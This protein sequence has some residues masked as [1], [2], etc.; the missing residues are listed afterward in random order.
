M[1]VG[2]P[3]REVGLGS[4]C[5]PI[6][7]PW[8]KAQIYTRSQRG[9]LA[10][11]GTMGKSKRPRAHRRQTIA[12]PQAMMMPTPFQ[13]PMMMP[14]Q[15]PMMMPQ[16]CFGLPPQK[17]DPRAAA[18]ISSS[19]SSRSSISAPRAKK[20]HTRKSKIPS[21]VQ[22]LGGIGRV[23]KGEALESLDHR[24]DATCLA[25]LDDAYLDK[26]LWILTSV[27]PTTKLADLRVPTWRILYGKLAISNKRVVERLSPVN[28]DEMVKR[29]LP[30]Q[31]EVIDAVAREEGWSDSYASRKR[32]AS[33]VPL[34]LAGMSGQP[35]NGTP[36]ASLMDSAMDVWARYAGGLG[37]HLQPMD[38]GL[39]AM[40]DQM[41]TTWQQLLEPQ[42]QASQPEQAPT[43]LEDR[44][45]LQ[46][47]QQHAPATPSAPVQAPATP[48]APQQQH[49]AP[50]APQQQPAP[51]T[52]SAPQPRAPATPQQPERPPTAAQD[53]E[54]PEGP[55]VTHICVICQSDMSSGQDD[56]LEALRCGHVFHAICLQEC[57][58]VTG[59]S[60]EDACPFKCKVTAA[61]IARVTGGTLESEEAVDDE[62]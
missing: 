41:G 24:L 12:A 15:Q 33:S 58:T 6:G 10:P 51:A 27:R 2:P 46:T 13:Q 16:G 60:R 29:M 55:I 3:S 28:Y 50:L 49:A 17:A 52:P 61:D 19:S 9:A 26:V 44:T 40:Q 7:K 37:V 48:S 11:N 1:H 5:R 35:S 21:T 59:K 18:A 62:G 54:Q 31:P 34:D 22:L 39:Q 43:P 30:M 25:D 8:L 57:L 38:R 56:V 20:R 42:L 47:L 45:Q 4:M 23:R 36:S 32:K 53:P 14:F